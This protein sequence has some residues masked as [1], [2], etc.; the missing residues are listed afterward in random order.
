MLD[1][2]IDQELLVQQAVKLNLERTPEVT[3]SIG[4]ERR[5][6]LAQSYLER[7]MATVSEPSEEEIAAYYNANPALY[8]ERKEYRFLQLAIDFPNADNGMAAEINEQIEAAAR[9]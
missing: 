7:V 9:A 1:R 2:L 5:Q 4:R 8:S 3:L 6:I